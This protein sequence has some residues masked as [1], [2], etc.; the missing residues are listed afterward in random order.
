MPLISR[1]EMPRVKTPLSPVKQKKS[2]FKAA[3]EGAQMSTTM[4]QLLDKLEVSTRS[5]YGSAPRQ[6]RGRLCHLKFIL[7]RAA[8]PKL[9]NLLVVDSGRSCVRKRAFVDHFL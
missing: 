1:T 3:S 7:R 2:P 6:I 9:C 8:N 5:C 4:V